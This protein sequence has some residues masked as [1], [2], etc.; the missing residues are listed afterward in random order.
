MGCC[1]G[2][3]EAKIE[4]KFDQ[5]QILRKELYTCRLIYRKYTQSCCYVR[6]N[7]ALVLT[8]NQLWFNLLCPNDREISI[9]LASIHDIEA[10]NS[11]RSHNRFIAG[12]GMI[13][14]D[15]DDPDS[16]M[17]DKI[18]FGVRGKTDWK[19]AIEATKANVIMKSKPV[20]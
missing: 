3:L 14:I 7:G 9:D 20:W 13:V 12:Q 15:F 18:V 11:F 4:E 8:A 5:S 1:N 16:G 6:G 19:E 17:R 10:T 2:K